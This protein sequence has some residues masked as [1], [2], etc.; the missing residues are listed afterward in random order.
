MPGKPLAV[1]PFLLLAVSGC[2]GD[3][4]GSARVSYQGNE[5]GSHDD[6]TTCDSDGTLTASANVREGQVDIRVTDGEGRALFSQQFDG[7][8]NLDAQ[9]LEG[10]SGTWRISAVRT[11]DSLLG[12][13]FEGD[14]SFRLAC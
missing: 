8:A 14:Y 11:S 1:L 5:N 6:S 2:I 7:G 12:T 9:A 13:P 3:S 10:S 4:G